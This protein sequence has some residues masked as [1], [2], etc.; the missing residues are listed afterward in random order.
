MKDLKS[1]LEIYQGRLLVIFP[2]QDDEIVMAGGLIQGAL[3][4]GW[5][6]KV[7]TVTDGGKGK[8]FIHGKGRSVAEIRKNELGVAMKRIGVSDWEVGGFGDA[9]LKYNR[10]WLSWVSKKLL[11]YDPQIVISYDNTGLTGHPDHIALSKGIFEISKTAKWDYWTVGP[12]GWSRHLFGHPHLRLSMKT[13][14]SLYCLSLK[15]TLH[16]W[17]A[18]MAYASQMRLASRLGLL[19]YW[20]LERCEGFSLADKR[21]KYDYQYVEFKV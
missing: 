12:V 6:V 16:K 17:W 15:E 9:T 5:Q 14:T 4:S 21:G 11:E 19:I 18:V 7:L 13:P 2:H 1:E 20:L 8:I 10:K 3:A